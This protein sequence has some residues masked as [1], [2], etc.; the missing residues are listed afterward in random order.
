MLNKKKLSLKELEKIRYEYP[1]G[2]PVELINIATRNAPLLHTKGTVEA[3]NNDGTVKV[4]WENGSNFIT[5]ACN[6]K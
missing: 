1:A 2:C 4:I 3:V 5:E 6:I